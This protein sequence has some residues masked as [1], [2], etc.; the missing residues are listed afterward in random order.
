MNPEENHTSPTRLTNK[1]NK[2]LWVQQLAVFIII[3]IGLWFRLSYVG[4]VE[5]YDPVIRADAAKYYTLSYNLTKNGVYSLGKKFPLTKTTE[6]TPGYP[7]FLASILS[8]ASNFQ[9]FYYGTLYIQAI[10]STLTIVLIHFTFYKIVPWPALTCGILF[11]SL[12]PHLI[13]YSGYVLTETLFTFLVALG[14]FFYKVS[15]NKESSVLYTITG[16]FWGLAALTRPALLLFPIA[17]LIFAW[18]FSN[19]RKSIF[20]KH[21]FIV[22]GVLTLWLPWKLFTI[23]TAPPAYSPMAA[24]FALGSYPDLTFKSSQLRGYPYREDSTT[25]NKMTKSF[26]TGLEVVSERARETPGKYLHWYLVGK[27]RM[28]WGATTVAG[29]GGAFQYGVK[30]SIYHTAKV[31]RATYVLMMS[32]HGFLAML[33][34]TYTVFLLSRT[35]RT[36]AYNKNP[37]IVITGILIVYFTLIHMV[38]AP[39]PRYAVPLYPFSYILAV[40]AVAA[41]TKKAYEFI[42]KQQGHT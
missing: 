9:E 35:V 38:L 12:S 10:L 20:I 40:G 15:F 25:Y 19:D 4:S 27:P 8:A 17:L 30:S 21:A 31:A 23:G 11:I 1:S 14:L 3:L 7:L 37:E 6:I 18:L 22:C 33:A 39:L 2:L 28:F 26:K 42:T 24:S 13:I 34:L 5:P 36:R 41:L 32:L 16:I 29:A